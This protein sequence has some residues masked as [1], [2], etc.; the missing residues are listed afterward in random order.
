MKNET[1]KIWHIEADTLGIY[2]GG[3][4]RGWCIGQTESWG[5]PNEGEAWRQFQIA[6]SEHSQI[7]PRLIAVTYSVKQ[8]QLN[9]VQG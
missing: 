7:A 4:V 3:P 6:K 2:W 9:Q 8:I 1:L 5:I